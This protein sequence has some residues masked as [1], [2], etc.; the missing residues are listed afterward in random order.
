MEKYVNLSD[1]EFEKITNKI[2]QENFPNF[3][4]KGKKI[5]GRSYI[6]NHCNTKSIGPKGIS[7]WMC[8]VCGEYNTVSIPPINKI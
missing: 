5:K 4:I 8:N 3:I 2:Q 6:C 7:K 1:Y